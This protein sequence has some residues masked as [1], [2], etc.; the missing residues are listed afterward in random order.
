MGKLK[1]KGCRCGNATSVPGKLTCCGQRCP[2]YVEGKACLDCRCRGC[3]NTHTPG[4][5]QL[6]PFAPGDA[7]GESVGD[8]SNTSASSL[9]HDLNVPSYVNNVMQGTSLYSNSPLSVEPVEQVPTMLLV[10]MKSLTVI[11]ILTWMFEQL[12]VQ[13]LLTQVLALEQFSSE[14]VLQLTR[15]IDRF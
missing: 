7:A 5:K 3:R 8:S 1:R 11:V 2:C 15:I 4:G 10:D 12:I 6:R 14:A 13:F 9:I